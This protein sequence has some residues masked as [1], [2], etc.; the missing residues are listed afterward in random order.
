MH[1][2]VGIYFLYMFDL[3][4]TGMGG[5]YL[6]EGKLIQKNTSMLHPMNC[7]G[8]TLATVSAGQNYSD[9]THSWTNET[10]KSMTQHVCIHNVSEWP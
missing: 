5:A 1:F 10:G 9:T 7:E 8:V 3:Q 6:Q 2:T 4:G